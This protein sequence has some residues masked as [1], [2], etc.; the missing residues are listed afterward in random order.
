LVRV[1]RNIEIGIVDIRG[2]KVRLGIV[3]PTCWPVHREEVADSMLRGGQVLA[4][5]LEAAL[6][7]V[8][9][10]RAENVELRAKLVA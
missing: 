3:A 7:E 6:Q 4:D 5:P 1:G 10:L 8:A 2:D 9:K